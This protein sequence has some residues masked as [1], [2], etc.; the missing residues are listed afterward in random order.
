MTDSLPSSIIYPI[1][2]KLVN[3]IFKKEKSVFIKYPVHEIISPKLSAC[4]KILFYASK[5]NK[6]IVGEAKIERIELL[7]K[8]EIINK[9][10]N[11]LFI[12]EE[13]F[14]DYSNN[15]QKKLLVYTL[16]NIKKYKKGIKVNHHITM[17]GEYVYQNLNQK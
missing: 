4:E 10:K 15:R 8:E 1:P 2:V 16:S 12:T 6:E 3:R 5:A 7:E 14:D 13:E 9:Y 17:A 11:E